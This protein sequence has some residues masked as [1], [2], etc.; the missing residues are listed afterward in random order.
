MNNY[1]FIATIVYI[2]MSIFFVIALLKKNNSIADIAWGLGFVLIT[3]F[4]FSRATDVFERT[5]LI[6]VLVLIWGLRLA[7]F[8]LKRNINKKE[9]FRYANWR[10]EWK[11]TF[12]IRTYLQ[13]FM[14]QG[15]I[16]FIIALPIMENNFNEIQNLN[17]FDIIGLTLWIIGF[18]FEAIGDYQLKQ[19]IAR[20]E[21]KGK[22]MRSGLWKYTRHPNYF[23]EATMWIGIAI[24]SI[25]SFPH[26]IFA[27]ISPFLIT[28][29]LLFVSGV[30][31]LEEKYAD[32]LEFQEY[33]RKTSKFIPWF[34]KKGE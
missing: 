14:L 4:S 8:I 19:F 21:N 28:Y 5:L 2:Y 24:I 3:V 25:R 1:L 11:R 10:K 23:G 34:V 16:M 31:L 22:I 13:V 33:A 20:R 9:D 26:P 30:P 27:V 17:V 29:L 18:L 32:N 15:F 6:N 12:L 7:Y